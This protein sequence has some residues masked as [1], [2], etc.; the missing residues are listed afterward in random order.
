[1]AYWQNAPCE[2]EQLVLFAS[3]LEDRIPED[4]P[5]RLLD[6]I[7]VS[8]DWSAWEAEYD[9]RRG[10]PP[11]HPRVLAGVLLYGMIRRIRSSRQLEYAVGNNV[12]FI[13]LAEG[14]SIFSA[15]GSKRNSKISTHT[16]AKRR[17]RWGC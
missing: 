15:R 12:D 10:Q 1:M 5:V 2:R 16:C 17:W 7:L 9:G 4:H 3:R 6:E 11:I 8:A 13:W 14:R